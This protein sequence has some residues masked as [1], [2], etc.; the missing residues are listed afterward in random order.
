MRDD[1][2]VSILWGGDDNIHD[3]RGCRLIGIRAGCGGLI[4]P[5]SSL[6]DHDIITTLQSLLFVCR[7]VPSLL[8][9]A[10]KLILLIFLSY[11][12]GSALK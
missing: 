4:P 9:I 8:S 12:Y 7:S 2:S 1:W 3:E 11:K 5:M 10:G 6:I